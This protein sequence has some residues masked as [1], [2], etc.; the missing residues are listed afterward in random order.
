[1][2]HTIGEKYAKG[3]VGF[4]VF[5]TDFSDESFQGFTTIKR[6][7]LIKISHCREFLWWGKQ[8]NNGKRSFTFK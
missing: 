3:N 2:L 8:T 4:F 5:V 1:M 7:S 6:K